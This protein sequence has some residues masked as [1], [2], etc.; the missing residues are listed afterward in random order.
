LWPCLRARS[1]PPRVPPLLT[2]AATKAGKRCATRR[3]ARDDFLRRSSSMRTGLERRG[4]KRMGQRRSSEKLADRGQEA[5]AIP[6]YRGR[7]ATTPA[8]A[9]E[10][11]GGVPEARA[12]PDLQAAFEF[13]RSQPSVNKKRIAA[14]GW[15]IYGHLATDPETLKNQRSYSW[16]V[17]RPGSR[18][19][20]R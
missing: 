12:K 15:C 11:I 18:H 4:Q 3:R 7:V 5:P 10:L 14:M 16:T 9:R 6:L 19:H 17:R 20:A 2:G 8:V 13:L 1:S